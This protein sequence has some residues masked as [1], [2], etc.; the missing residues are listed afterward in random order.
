MTRQPTT[1]VTVVFEGDELMLRLQAR[2]IARYAGALTD[3]RIIVIE[4]F[5]SPRSPAWRKRQRALYG[6]FAPNVRFVAADDLTG[7]IR[8]EG[9]WKQQLL[10]LA[11]VRLV[12]T[13][14]YLVIDGK[15]LLIRDLRPEDLFAADGRPKMAISGYAAHP[16]ELFF[17]QA[18]AYFNLDRADWIGRFV[19]TAPPFTVD[20]AVCRDLIAHVENREGAAFEAAFLSTGVT[21]F[22][23]YGAWIASQRGALEAVY[24]I[25]ALNCQT[26]WP[27]EASLAKSCA[28]F[29]A[30][31]AEDT[32]FFA[33]HRRALGAMSADT[34]AMLAHRLHRHGLDAPDD[35]ALKA[36]SQ[37]ARRGR[38][39]Q[40]MMDF[41][42]RISW[43]LEALRNRLRRP[44]A[45]IA[46]S[47]S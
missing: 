28:K 25:G 37:T 45:P 47:A 17:D 9:W 13:D 8:A 32:A 34:I 39:E 29:E 18:M 16:L 10:K 1:F 5:R 40:A 4:N 41:R 3:T 43:R 20:T 33:I 36:L 26:I 23:L 30:A 44:I 35:T 11:V 15:T 46:G 7:T 12:D 31:R 6:A 14:T 19:E 24:D 22:F 27:H 42:R 38:R 21:E 2:S